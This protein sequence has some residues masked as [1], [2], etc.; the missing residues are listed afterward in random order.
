[1]NPWMQLVYAL[2]LSAFHPYFHPCFLNRKESQTAVFF[3]Q[4]PQSSW[5]L[6]FLWMILA[7]LDL[8]WAWKAINLGRLELIL[9]FSSNLLFM[10]VLLLRYGRNTSDDDCV[11]N[12][13]VSLRSTESHLISSLEI[14][15]FLSLIP[16]GE[17]Q[18]FWCFVKRFWWWCGRFCHKE[19]ETLMETLGSLG[20]Y[21]KWGEERTIR[22]CWYKESLPPSFLTARKSAWEFVYCW[23]QW[24]RS[25]VST[26]SV[27]LHCVWSSQNDTGSHHKKQSKDKLL[28]QN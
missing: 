17:L 4:K 6:R 20:C 8:V 21:R 12:C 11:Y 18:I 10:E 9:E 7:L 5:P 19:R 24:Q 1:M 2:S 27:Y 25:L 14:H 16:L 26:V 28:Y 23:A 13:D 3:L 15:T 22:V